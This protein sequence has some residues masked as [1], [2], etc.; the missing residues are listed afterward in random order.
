MC[1]R[2]V[3]VRTTSPLTTCHCNM[4]IGNL[5][6]N[7]PIVHVESYCFTP[8]AQLLACIRVQLHPN[9]S[10]ISL[11]YKGLAWRGRTLY[12]CTFCRYR[13]KI[14]ELQC[15]RP[16]EKCSQVLYDLKVQSTN[17][18]TLTFHILT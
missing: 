16:G 9:H 8:L 15:I 2:F 6:C 4:S 7:M 10:L 11:G 5:T 14:R 3:L 1:H 17:I 18:C 12:R 13:E